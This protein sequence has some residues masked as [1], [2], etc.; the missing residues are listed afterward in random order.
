MK[1]I[2]A[3]SRDIKSLEDVRHAIHESGYSVTELVSGCAKGVDALG[4]AWA[5]AAGV[6]IKRFRP[7]WAGQGSYAGP[8]RNQRM[9]DYAEALVAVTHSPWTPGTADMIRRARAKGLLVYVKEVP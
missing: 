2:V 9:A 6:P 8:A 3:G 7:N 5:R 1:V 4:E